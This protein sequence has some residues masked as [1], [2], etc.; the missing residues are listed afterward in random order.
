MAR[1]AGVRRSSGLVAVGLG[2]R[3]TACVLATV[4]IGAGGGAG[5][6]WLG[7]PAGAVVEDADHD[8]HCPHPVDE[9]LDGADGSRPCCPAGA[10]E[11]EEP[12]AQPGPGQYGWPVLLDPLGDADQV[13]A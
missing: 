7:R 10:Q 9:D 6:D 13:W 4:I 2:G 5:E 11:K 8:D 1:G 3:V 12:G